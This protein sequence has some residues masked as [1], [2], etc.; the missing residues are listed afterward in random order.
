MDARQW[1][2]C[3]RWLPPEIRKRIALR[4]I[5]QDDVNGMARA[6]AGAIMGDKNLKA[7]AV[8]IEKRAARPGSLDDRVDLVIPQ[9]VCEGY[10]GLFR[11]INE[12]RLT[13][14]WPSTRRNENSGIRSTQYLSFHRGP[15]IET[16][17]CRH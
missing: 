8:I 15:F 2:C 3:T 9:A 6:G 7:V 11:H 1:R 17:R 4:T 13:A 12:H 14:S 5:V 10:P 16:T